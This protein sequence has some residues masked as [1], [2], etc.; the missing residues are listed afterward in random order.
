[1]VKIDTGGLGNTVPTPSRTIN[2]PQQSGWTPANVKEIILGIK[3][4]I[5]EA[6][7]FQGSGQAQPA[8]LPEP[9]QHVEPRLTEQ[10]GLTIIQLKTMAG[11]FLDRLIDGGY[12]DKSIKDTIEDL[13]VTIKQIRGM[14]K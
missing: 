8:Q 13:P 1:M 2:P 5:D 10:S 4:L 12:G 9:E 14:L 3:T 7:A 11:G 6:K